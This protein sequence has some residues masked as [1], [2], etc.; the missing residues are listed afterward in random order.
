MRS[1]FGETRLDIVAPA[2]RMN[3]QRDEALDALD[4]IKDRKIRLMFATLIEHLP[5]EK[6]SQVA[7]ETFVATYIAPVLQGTLRTNE[8]I[9]I[10]FPNTAS[11]AQKDE[12]VRADRPDIT[13]KIG[14]RELLI[15]EVTGPCQETNH[16]KNAWDLYRLARFGKAL[17]GSRPFAPLIQIVHT[18]GVYMRL[19][20]KARGMFLLER[21]GTFVVPTS[22]D[23]VPSLLGTI[24]TLAA[25]K[26]DLAVL[27]EQKPENRKRS[28]DFPD[29]PHAKKFLV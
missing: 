24:Q 29:L 4:S 18:K 9:S 25:A 16:A 11:M 21:V 26:E 20:V 23:M 15:G 6:E 13:A 22:I 2:L 19:T 7:E 12:G 1:V 14:R 3:D 5:L 10:H 17:L 8:K 28:W 27:M